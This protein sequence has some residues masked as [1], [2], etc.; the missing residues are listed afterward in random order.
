MKM[1]N[2]TLEAIKLEYKLKKQLI[3]LQHKY[4]M[5]ELEY[6]RKTNAIKH[7]NMLEI[8]RIRSAEIRKTLERK[9]NFFKGGKYGN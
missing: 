7:E 9:A 3:E 6:T 8:N 5:E 2:K 4:A 1:E